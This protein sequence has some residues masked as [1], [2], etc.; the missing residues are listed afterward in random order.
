MCELWE[1]LVHSEN[2]GSSNADPKW[3]RVFWQNDGSGINQRPDFWEV[4]ASM[5]HVY[6]SDLTELSAKTIK[7]RDGTVVP[8]DTIICATGWDSGFNFLSAQERSR[9]GLPSPRAD[10]DSDAA[11]EWQHL[12]TQAREE[13]L[14]RF[15]SL[16]HPPAHFA[17]QMTTTPYRLYKAIA[18]LDDKSVVILG[19]IQV[20]NNFMAAECQA[21]WAVAYFDGRI[22]LPPRTVMAKEIALNNAWCS[23]RYLDKGNLGT[24]YYF[25]L[26]PYVD[27]LLGHI[28]F[29][30][31]RRPWPLSV[32]L[33][34]TAKDLRELCQ[35]Y[36]EAQNIWARVG[37]QQSRSDLLLFAG[38]PLNVPLNNFVPRQRLVLVAR[39]CFLSA[40]RNGILRKCFFPATS[41]MNQSLITGTLRSEE[42]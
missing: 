22:D 12:D 10:E 24:W 2:L 26:V 34:V 11:T 8:A 29:C 27:M 9:L 18:P 16:A 6:R 36:K 19:H 32:L 42:D 38:Y 40:F 35:E 39:G 7:L 31:Y 21:L 4:I 23:L 33:P 15:P 30:P 1:I 37:E 25:D 13:V 17:R 3:Y 41:C 5:V 14:Q 28:G 20:G